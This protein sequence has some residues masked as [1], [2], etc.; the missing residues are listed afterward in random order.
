MTPAEILRRLNAVKSRPVPVLKKTAGRT[1]RAEPDPPPETVRSWRYLHMSIRL[2]ADVTLTPTEG[3]IVRLL[4]D[5]LV[6]GRAEMIGTLDDAEYGS[7]DSVKV[8]V[9]KLRQILIPCG[10]DILFET[11]ADGYR[12]VRHFHIDE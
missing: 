6:H 12:A 11:L 5:G 1:R 8:R 9:C 4:S 3:R 10:Y 7:F 2:P